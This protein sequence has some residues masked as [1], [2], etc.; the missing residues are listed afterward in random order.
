MLLNNKHDDGDDRCYNMPPPYAERDLVSPEQL[1][2][3]VDRG[4]DHRAGDHG[5]RLTEAQVSQLGSVRVVQL[6]EG[7]AGGST[8]RNRQRIN[9]TRQ[10][11]AALP[12]TERWFTVRECSG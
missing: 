9:T 1:G 11:R 12:D 6:R 10:N 8:L 4:A 2:R 3:H 7:G 5:L